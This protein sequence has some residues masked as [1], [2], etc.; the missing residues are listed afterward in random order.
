MALRTH[1]PTTPGQ[2]QLAPP[3]R[4]PLDGDGEALGVEPVGGEAGE[5]RGDVLVDGKVKGTELVHR[6]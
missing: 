3:C 2:R 6:P 5:D 1:N 4:A